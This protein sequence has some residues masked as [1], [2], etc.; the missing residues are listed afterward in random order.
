MG[1]L[2]GPLCAVVTKYGPIVVESD[3]LGLLVESVA[4]WDMEVGDLP[5]VECVA[6]GRLV[7]AC[8]IVKYA[9]FEVV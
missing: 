2:V 7:K 1:L 5:I 8:F 4:H 3:P 9:L 6:C